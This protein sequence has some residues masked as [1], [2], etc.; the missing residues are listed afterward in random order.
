MGWLFRIALQLAIGGGLLH[1][2]PWPGPLSAVLGDWV[3]WV[4]SAPRQLSP[5]HS[6]PLALP[7]GQLCISEATNLAFQ[8]ISLGFT[9]SIL[10]LFCC[11]CNVPFPLRIMGESVHL[12]RPCRG[13]LHS[14]ASF[15]ALCN[16]RELQLVLSLADSHGSLFPHEKLLSLFVDSS[17]VLKKCW[18]FYKMIRCLNK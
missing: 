17:W 14:L 13:V 18:L 2:S 7:W 3:D 4:L 9:V 6:L 16:R 5:R 12:A 1:G 10:S 15:G 11:G 8:I